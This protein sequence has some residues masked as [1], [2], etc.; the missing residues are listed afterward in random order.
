M[1]KLLFLNDFFC[2][3]RLF[4]KYFFFLKNYFNDVSYNENNLENYDF[5]ICFGGGCLLA[6]DKL[7]LL[8]NKIIILITPYLDFDL[9][10]DRNSDIDKL[11]SLYSEKT[12]IDKECLNK[13]LKFDNIKPVFLNEQIVKD[14]KIYIIYGDSNKIIPL[15]FCLK[16]GMILHGVS[17]HLIEN[18]GYA[19]FIDNYTTF[20]KI[21]ED[22]IIDENIGR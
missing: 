5:I 22:V 13:N 12:G 16:I 14:N 6:L 10:F 8:K 18:A 3:N 2:N 1:E 21:L 19:P 17:F 11:I 15:D 9:F 7:S 4:D 20:R